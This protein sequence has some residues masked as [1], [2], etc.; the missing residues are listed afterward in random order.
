MA[1]VFKLGRDKKKKNAP[2]YFEYKDQDGKKR[3]RKGF[4]RQG[5]HRAIGSKAGNRGSHAL[6]GSN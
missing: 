2:W 4:Y 5:H 1:S 3:M 6:D